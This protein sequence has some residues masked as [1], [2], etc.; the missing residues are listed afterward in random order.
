MKS[1]RCSPWQGVVRALSLPED[2]CLSQSHMELFGQRELILEGVKEIL[3]YSDDSVHLVL[4]G[5]SVLVRGNDIKIE[6]FREAV[7]I[8]RGNIDA[9]LFE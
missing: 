9:I 2:A 5:H 3:E 4:K 8:I 7:M 6:M 1:E